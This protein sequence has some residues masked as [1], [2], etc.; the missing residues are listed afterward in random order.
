[1][2]SVVCLA[3][4]TKHIC[5]F[6]ILIYSH[7]NQNTIFFV[8]RK[9]WQH[10]QKHA[11]CRYVYAWHAIIG[12]WGGIKVGAADMEHYESTM[13]YPIPSQGVL[14][15]EPGMKTDTLTVH[16]VGLVHPTKVF[17][18][19]NELHSYLA[20]AGV[21]GVKVDVQNVLETLG[22]GFG[23]RVLLTRHYHQALEDSVAQNFPNNGCIACMSHNTDG[24]YRYKR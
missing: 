1:M 23:G 5:N 6:Y 12:Y 2:V 13:E 17:Q 9:L 21:D 20:A 7:Y 3:S 24:L 18:F 22:T 15:N 10:K 4:V 14:N 16:G 8:S 11:V 19:F